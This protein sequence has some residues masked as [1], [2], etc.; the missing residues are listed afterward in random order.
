MMMDEITGI[1]DFA[2][3]RDVTY[4]DQS[5]PKT[6]FSKRSKI[7]GLYIR[8]KQEENTRRLCDI[9]FVWQLVEQH[10]DDLGDGIS[11]KLG[12]WGA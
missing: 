10:V 7:V 3:W 11:S 12:R 4:K 1:N 6:I 9:L 2:V 5:R 8:R